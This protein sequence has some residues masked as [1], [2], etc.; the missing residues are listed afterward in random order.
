MKRVH[1][2]LQVLDGLQKHY[3]TSGGGGGGL[4]RSDH[5]NTKIKL[6]NNMDGTTG[7]F[8]PQDNS[9][10]V[11]VV[12]L[13]YDPAV[14]FAVTISGG[15]LTWTERVTAINGPSSNYYER[16]S[17]FTAP[18]STAASM[19]ISVNGNSSGGADSPIASVQAFSFTGYNTGTPT[20]A[21]ATDANGLADGENAMTLSGSPASSSVVIAARSW[22]AD[23][24]NNETA[25]P[26]TSGGWAEIYDNVPLTGFSGYTCLQS[27]ART[28]STSTDV[29]WDDTA[30]NGTGFFTGAAVALEIQAA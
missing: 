25:T 16:L 13:V 11:V 1:G 19:T 2:G 9:L 20:G 24:A 27:Q 8:T 3:F 18:V 5:L 29:R 26:D 14:S 21:T 28:G 17:I 30:D 12:S 7:S 23:S 6:N 4:S 15:S 22:T 10:L